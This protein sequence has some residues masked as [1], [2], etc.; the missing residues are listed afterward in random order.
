MRSYWRRLSAGSK[1]VEYFR[2]S[3][4]DNKKK[5]SFFDVNDNYTIYGIEGIHLCKRTQD[6]SSK[7]TENHV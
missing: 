5:R 4:Y 6:Q 3:L 7:H 2:Y 1:I